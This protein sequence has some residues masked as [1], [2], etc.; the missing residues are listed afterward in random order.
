M[1]YR[2]LSSFNWN[3]ETLNVAL[4]LLALLLS[5]LEVLSTNLVQEISYLF[6]LYS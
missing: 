4:R 6:C 5:I 2:R 3:S 1:G